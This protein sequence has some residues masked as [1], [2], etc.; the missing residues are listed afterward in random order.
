M[1][2]LSTVGGIGRRSLPH[3]DDEEKP[4]DTAKLVELMNEKRKLC[5]R[6]VWKVD[7]V[8]VE[9]KTCGQSSQDQSSPQFSSTMNKEKFHQEENHSRSI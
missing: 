3:S 1:G 8:V 5:Q 6:L 4:D 9:W 7:G 2:L